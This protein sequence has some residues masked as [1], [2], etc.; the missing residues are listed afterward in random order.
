MSDNRILR[1]MYLNLL[2]GTCSVIN[3][4]DSLEEYY[5]LIDCETFDITCRYINGKKFNIMCDDFGFL[6]NKMI[7]AMS[8]PTDVVLVGNLL[9]FS[10]DHDDDGNLLS[11]SNDDIEHL[12]KSLGF[13]FIDNFDTSKE[14]LITPHSVVIL[15]GIDKR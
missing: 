12:V 13:Y 15:C 9:V 14:N 5:R 8:S 7:S 10:G 3:V 4:F 1:A 2:D 6:N 11:L